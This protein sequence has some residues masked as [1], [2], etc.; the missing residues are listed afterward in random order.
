MSIVPLTLY[1]YTWSHT[2]VLVGQFL[3]LKFIHLS[4]SLQQCPPRWQTKLL[5]VVVMF[6]PLLECFIPR[7]T[8]RSYSVVYEVKGQTEV[9]D[10]LFPAGRKW[11]GLFDNDV[12]VILWIKT[13]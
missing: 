1:N 7:S 9:N 13:E 2:F 8:R 6:D 12:P 5:G 3:I 10:K 4:H 11:S